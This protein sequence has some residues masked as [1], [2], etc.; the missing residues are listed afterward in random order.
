MKDDREH[1]AILGGGVGGCVAA[2]WL[3]STE[4]LRKKYRVTLYQ[5]GWRLG[6]KG[7]SSR[8]PEKKFRSEEHGPHVWFGFYENAFTTLRRC[9]N[10]LDLKKHPLGDV[11]RMFD[12]DIDDGGQGLF[13]AS[14][15]GVFFNRISGKDWYPWKVEMDRY[16]GEPGDGDPQP[17]V[18]DS[19][20]RA[21]DLLA[22]N[23]KLQRLFGPW[24]EKVSTWLGGILGRR[25]PVSQPGTS[26]YGVNPG[27]PGGY[28]SYLSRRLVD[29]AGTERH[30]YGEWLTGRILQVL[31]DVIGWKIRRRARRPGLSQDELRELSLLDLCRTCLRGALVDVLIRDKTFSQLDG[32]EFLQWLKHHGA[33]YHTL[34]SSTFLRG[35]YDTP[36]AF[37]KGMAHSPEH[38]NFSAGAALRGFFR[39][40]FGHKGAYLY[41]MKLGMGECVFT[42]LYLMLKKQDVKIEFFHRVESLVPNAAGNRVERVELTRQARVT[43]SSGDYNPI[44]HVTIGGTVWPYWPDRPDPAQLDP[45]SLPASDD[46]GLDSAWSAHRGERVHLADR[47]AEDDAAIDRFDHVILAIPP[48]AHRRIAGPLMAKDTRFRVMVETSETIRTL[49]CQIWI[50]AGDRNDINSLGWD[51]TH[52][53]REYLLGAATPDPLNVIL[54]A[55]KILR[56][57]ATVGATHVFYFCGPD[58]DDPKEPAFG[59]DPGYPARAHAKAKKECIEYLKENLF[60]WPGLCKGDGITFDPAT[61]YHPDP[62]A[63]PEE[64]LDWQYFR[65]NLDPSERYV[66]STTESTPNRLAPWDTGFNNLVHAGDWCRNGIDIG[67]VESAATSA[68]LAAHHLTGYPAKDMIAG[69]HYE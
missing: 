41:R 52:S 3:S 57:E 2:Y 47:R 45:A 29:L 7:A 51:K 17:D 64:K 54:D 66:L 53:C 55:T 56:T 63:G 69:M 58:L 68:M 22:Y 4:E 61:L 31:L 62:A 34:E 65:I 36:F 18:R 11:D 44:A 49:A 60:L 35:Y 38:A 28:A 1:I 23:V 32:Q 13:E 24:A 27:D 25:L 16:P 43:T 26:R 42:P 9:V 6:G 59:S 37:S 33:T 20:W 30:W 67:C 39:I 12:D 8:N 48:G 19:L 46:P 40:F 10:E 14:R 5:T 15:E 21:A 50:S